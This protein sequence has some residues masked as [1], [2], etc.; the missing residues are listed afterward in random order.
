MADFEVAYTFGHEPLQQYLIDTGQGRLQP[1]QIAWNT[2]DGKWFHLLPNEKA[3]PG[4]VLHWTGRY[5]TA[6]T[7]CIT[8]HTTGFEKR[9][10]AQ[11]DS[12]RFA[13][14]R[15]ERVLPVLPRPGLA[16]CRMGA[17]QGRRPG[18]GADR[19]PRPGGRPEDAEGPG[20]GLRRLPF[21]PQPN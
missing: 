18:A 3:P 16:P 8:C 4:D 13:L 6:N 2:R 20:R 12:L 9:Y 7:M 21:A 14:V 15:S 1:L 11:A 19:A 17:A 5:Q 10:D